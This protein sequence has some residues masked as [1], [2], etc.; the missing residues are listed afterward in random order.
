M[1]SGRRAATYVDASS[2]TLQNFVGHLD[3][4][5]SLLRSLPQFEFIYVAPMSRFFEAAQLESS[6]RVSASNGTVPRE[7]LLR[8]FGARKQWETGQ[9][10]SAADGVFLNTTKPQLRDPSVECQYTQWARG[11][12]TEA[13]INVASGTAE[14]HNRATLVTQQ[15]GKSLSVFQLLD[16]GLGE[17]HHNPTTAA[18]SP[19][20]SPDGL[21]P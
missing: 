18:L 17:R 11:T 16:K 1:P 2:L 15:C 6:R 21:A 19:R 5:Q 7:L 14:F 20:R 12:L 3:A 10:V 13:E 9:R 8:Y 4:Y